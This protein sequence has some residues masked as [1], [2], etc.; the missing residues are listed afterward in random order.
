LHFSLASLH[1]KVIQCHNFQT[2][3]REIELLKPVTLLLTGSH[4]HLM[5]RVFDDHLRIFE[6]WRRQKLD[7]VNELSSYL[8]Q[9]F[10]VPVECGSICE[11]PYRMGGWD[12]VVLWLPICQPEVFV[13]QQKRRSEHAPIIR[14][15]CSAYPFSHDLQYQN[16]R[17][18]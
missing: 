17:V 11:G 18:W 7:A 15:S 8:P 6:L 12:Q 2:A 14:L 13:S 16:C 9:E 4:A 5:C 10:L 3:C 1:R